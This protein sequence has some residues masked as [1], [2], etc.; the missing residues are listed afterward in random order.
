M[1]R[2]SPLPWVWRRVSEIFHAL[3]FADAGKGL[4][5]GLCVAFLGLTADQLIATRAAKR[6][7]QLGLV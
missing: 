1:R 4:V 3:T 7:A 2:P 5:I 6:R